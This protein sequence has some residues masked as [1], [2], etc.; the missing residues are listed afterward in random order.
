MSRKANK[1]VK[2]DESCPQT[3]F[4]P[5]LTEPVSPQSVE[6][7]AVIICHG[8]GQQ[9]PFET[10][11][12]NAGR[13]VEPPPGTAL[14]ASETVVRHVRFVNQDATTG[15]QPWLPRA[16]I[17]VAPPTPPPVNDEQ[18]NPTNASQPQSASVYIQIY[19][20]L[21]TPLPQGQISLTESATRPSTCRATDYIG[22]RRCF[23][24]RPV[25]P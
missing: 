20:I 4:F 24:P 13:L 18:N 23:R 25:S 22:S 6:T 15:K 12:S 3:S 7:V 10:L 9:V 14:P 11:N 17:K 1:S 16:E 21:W 19:Y 2:V 8:V 5:S